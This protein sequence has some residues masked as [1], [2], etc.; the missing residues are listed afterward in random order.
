MAGLAYAWR[1]AAR[2]HWARWLLLVALLGLA[3]G[4]SVAAIA[5]ARRTA[6]AYPRYVDWARVPDVT[7]EPPPGPDEGFVDRVRATPGVRSAALSFG[8]GALSVDDRGRLRPGVLDQLLGSAGER[9]YA[10]DRPAVRAGRLPARDAADEVLVNEVLAGRLGLQTGDRLPVQLG[11]IDGEPLGAP[12]TLRVVGIGLLSHEVV[13]DDVGRLGVAIAGPA[14]VREHADAVQF[15]RLG[16][17]LAA[18]RAGVSSFLGAAQRLA[19]D[20]Y[21]VPNE[22]PSVFVERT[23]RAIRPQAVALG[24]FGT[25][26]LVATLV[27]VGQALARH[28]GRLADELA[29]MAALGVTRSVFRRLNGAIASTIAVAGA[30]L[31]V[32]VGVAASP[33][34]PIGAVRAAEIDPGV[35]LDV[36]VLAAGALLIVAVITGL[37][38]LVRRRPASV[39]IAPAPSAAAEWMARAGL[40]PSVETGVRMVLDPAP[41]SR[42]VGFRSTVAAVTLAVACL[43]AAVTF[44]AG[45]DRLVHRP[46]LYG[47]DWDLALHSSGGWGSVP[48]GD[49]G[50]RLSA[51]PGVAAWGSASSTP[52]SVR[53]DGVDVPTL[54][55][56]AGQTVQPP[57][58][59]GRAALAADEVVLGSSTLDR[60]GKRIGDTVTV[61]AGGKRARLTVVGRAVFPSIGKVDATRV[62][63]GDGGWLPHAFLEA[64]G[65]DLEPS[66][67]FVRLAGGAAGQRAAASIRRLWRDAHGTQE[68]LTAQRPADIV[69]YA[70]MGSSPAIFA[71]VLALVAVAAVGHTVASTVRRRERDVALLRAIGFV[72][73]QV[74]AAVLAQAAVLLAAA[75][76]V[77][78][79]I[80]VAAGRT[81]W[82]SYAESIGVVAEPVVPVAAIALVVVGAIAIVNVLAAGPAL[83][84]TRT[85][86]A[87]GLRAE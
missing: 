14:F 11:T 32:V 53:Y 79:P 81:T 64:H 37:A 22:D 52:E 36:P 45:L 7:I 8:Y 18:G 73:R 2:R 5:G 83:A 38:A 86:P 19:P 49:L 27:V 47:W 85:V 71:G 63:L 15:G 16:V 67:V 4:I 70:A 60:L 78:L 84:A 1:A 29:P 43:A 68:V 74:W 42:P 80:G 3:G 25:L 50:P 69:N 62:G 66:V 61:S 40:P 46:A 21:D 48:V 28:L 34:A 10:E 23:Q 13:Q 82:R 9:F 35:A 54:V 72:R 65:V 26:A 51:M 12:I 55:V 87:R 33:L 24:A 77:G 6:S 58:V 30:V 20:G 41:G 56:A 31:A 17:H 44:G 57:I 75:L 39:P 59:A 76:A